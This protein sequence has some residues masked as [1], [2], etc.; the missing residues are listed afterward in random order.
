M[1]IW[2]PLPQQQQMQQ[3][4]TRP[5]LVGI[6]Y[7]GANTGI[8]HANRLVLAGSQVVP[9][10]VM[11]SHTGFR[12]DDATDTDVDFRTQTGSAETDDLRITDAHGFW[13][14]QT[15]P[16]QNTFHALL[17]QEGLFFF[18]DLGEAV[19]PPGPFSSAQVVMRENSWYGSDIGRTVLIVGGQVIYVQTGGED[20]RGLDWNEQQRKYQSVSLLSRSGAVF[21]TALDMTY[22]PSSGRDGETVIV[23]DGNGDAAVAVIAADEP[24]PAWAQWSTGPATHRILAATSPRGRTT[25]LV[26]RDGV[27][28]LETLDESRSSDVVLDA[29]GAMASEQP[30]DRVL[31]TLPFVARS[32]TGTKRSVRKSRIFDCAVD[33]VGVGADDPAPVATLFNGKVVRPTR[34]KQDTPDITRIRYGGR[35][36]WRDRSSITLTFREHVEIAG[37]AYKAAS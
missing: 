36:G 26:D 16:R 3:A 4:T 13:F 8:V 19:I 34:K 22:V 27:V 11:A 37:I 12:P 30:F 7:G 14:R 35:R 31:E 6:D 9:D 2:T 20:A 32:Q 23:V 28:A 33:F 5:P 24:W 17:Q 15:S 18:G 21:S 29:T 10:L 25:F 1:T